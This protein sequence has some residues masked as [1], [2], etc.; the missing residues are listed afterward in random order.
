MKP[1]SGGCPIGDRAPGVNTGGWRR[2]LSVWRTHSQHKVVVTHSLLSHSHTYTHTLS[3]F[4]VSLTH[5]HTYTYSF[6]CH[7]HNLY[8][9]YSLSHTHTHTRFSFCHPLH[10]KHTH[11]HTI[12]AVLWD[13][14]G[15]GFNS[16]SYT[17][18]QLLRGKTEE[19]PP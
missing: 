5:T 18:F 7:A 12:C 17:P 11:T 10:H 15:G 4:F 1:C 16:Y 9:F 19:P 13:G 3:S 2:I 8:L 6:H 14:C